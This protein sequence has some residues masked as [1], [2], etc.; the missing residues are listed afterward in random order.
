MWV[1][2]HWEHKINR[3][4]KVCLV[5]RKSDKLYSSTLPLPSAHTVTL[6]QG[7]LWTVFV[8]LTLQH[9]S[10]LKQ[11]ALRP[12]LGRSWLQPRFICQQTQSRSHSSHHR[13]PAKWH[14]LTRLPSP[15]GCTL[16]LD[17]KVPGG[18]GLGPVCLPSLHLKVRWFRGLG[19]S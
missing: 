14:K 1:L 16:C 12:G 9:L 5:Y 7:A 15:C 18:P 2:Q 6:L 4:L 3:N 11:D 8:D 10:V 19:E 17:K 13:R